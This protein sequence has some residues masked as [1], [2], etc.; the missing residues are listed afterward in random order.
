MLHRL[1]RFRFGRVSACLL[2]SE[3]HF[4]LPS[5]PLVLMVVRLQQQHHGGGRWLL[6]WCWQQTAVVLLVALLVRCVAMVAAVVVLK[7]LVAG[8]WYVAAIRP[9]F[10]RAVVGVVGGLALEP[11]ATQ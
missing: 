10:E 5:L 7:L 4:L 8:V 9:P 1:A 3:Q 11:I 2:E 6:G